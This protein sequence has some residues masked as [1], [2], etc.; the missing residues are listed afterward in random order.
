MAEVGATWL[1]FMA[2]EWWVFR[3]HAWLRVFATQTRNFLCLEVFGVKMSQLIHLV[4]MGWKHY[5][6][7]MLLKNQLVKND[8]GNLLWGKWGLVTYSCPKKSLHNCGSRIRYFDFLGLDCFLN[9]F[10]LVDRPKSNDGSS[11]VTYCMLQE[12]CY[13]RHSLWEHTFPKPPSFTWPLAKRL[14]LLRIAYQV[15]KIQ[16]NLLFQGPWPANSIHD[17]DIQW[18][19]HLEHWV[20]DVVHP[21]LPPAAPY[22]FRSKSLG[23]RRTMIF[24][25]SSV[26]E[27][28][29][30]W[31]GFR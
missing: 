16:L 9:M 22:R 11:D 12:P 25:I 31:S 7:R 14:K 19:I 15:G 24:E 29:Q 20:F 3:K 18:F 8:G 6:L 27:W 21:L 26:E 13:L 30:K 17:H 1:F 10:I 2:W 4:E 5:I 23:T 28:V